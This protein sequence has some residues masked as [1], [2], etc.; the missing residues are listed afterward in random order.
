MNPYQYCSR[1]GEELND[2]LKE[3]YDEEHTGGPVLCQTCVIE[4]FKGV[5]KAMQAFAKTI[6]QA[7]EEAF[8]PLLTEKDTND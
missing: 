8:G 7:L 1:C 4:V 5:P 6:G 3:K 2:S